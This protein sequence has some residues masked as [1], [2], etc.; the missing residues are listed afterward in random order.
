MYMY[1]HRILSVTFLSVSVPMSIH[2][3]LSLLPIVVAIL[4]TPRRHRIWQFE[5]GR[6]YACSSPYPAFMFH[7]FAI[8]LFYLPSRISHHHASCSS[9]SMFISILSSHLTLT[10]SLTETCIP[11]PLA[12]LPP[13]PLAAMHPPSNLQM[14][15]SN[16]VVG[17]TLRKQYLKLRK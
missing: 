12:I 7:S 14:L 16:V 2:S 3:L 10:P 4:S 13:Q 5:E 15:M 17:K 8:H 11:Y 1:T 6:G 9:I